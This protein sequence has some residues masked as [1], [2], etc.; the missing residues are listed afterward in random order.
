MGSRVEN[1]VRVPIDRVH[2]LA[3]LNGHLSL[4]KG[5][6]GWRL[7]LWLIEGYLHTAELEGRIS[8]VFGD[9]CWENILSFFHS[10][11]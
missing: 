11:G 2:E 7:R 9:K 1:L 8:E 10:A 6:E 4:F 5:V 3:T